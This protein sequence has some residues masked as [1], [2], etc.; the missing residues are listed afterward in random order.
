MNK[1]YT[2]NGIFE[3]KTYNCDWGR[4]HRLDGPAVEKAN[5]TKEWWVN[6]IR[7]RED[8]PAIE[9]DDGIK[10]WWVNGKQ[11]RIDGPAAEF[12]DGS[13]EWWVEGK[14]LSEE[15]FKKLYNNI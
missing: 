11:H 14:Y 10:H 1:Y 15:D 7:H 2:E 9:Y 8:G 13:K 3:G 4:L 5:G 12:T 6:G